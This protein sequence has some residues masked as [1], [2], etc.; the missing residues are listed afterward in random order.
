MPDTRR[1]NDRCVS[2]ECSA[3]TVLYLSSVLR[4]DV[5]VDLLQ[6]IIVLSILYLQGDSP[7]VYRLP[8]VVDRLFASLAPRRPYGVAGGSR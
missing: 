6:L 3:L 1:A 4:S 2:I 7:N 8:M 5:I